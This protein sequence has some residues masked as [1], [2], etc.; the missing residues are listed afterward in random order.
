MKDTLGV[1]LVIFVLGLFFYFGYRDDYR[2]NPKEFVRIIIGVPVSFVANIFG[3]HIISG[4]IRKWIQDAD[5][6]SDDYIQK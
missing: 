5:E 6:K 3:M 4:K 1:L 2:R